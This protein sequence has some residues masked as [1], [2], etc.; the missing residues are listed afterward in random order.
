MCFGC[1]NPLR[2]R[3]RVPDPPNDLVIVSKM[4]RE[5]T[6]QG[7]AR[8]KIGNVYF[9]CNLRCI[10]RKEQNFESNQLSQILPHLQ[11]SH[12]QHLSRNLGL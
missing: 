10:R 12:F 2:Q 6:Y 11:P 5:W 9:H 7:Q 4:L 1:G 3:D 8:S